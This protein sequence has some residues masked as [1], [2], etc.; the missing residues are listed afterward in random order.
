MP[1]E[2]P[3]HPDFDAAASPF[4]NAPVGP[5]PAAPRPVPQAPRPAAQ[6]PLAPQPA[7]V[8]PVTQR[9][10]SPQPAAVAYQRP[11]AAAPQPVAANAALRPI[12][13]KSTPDKHDF[14]VKRRREDDDE[15]R[16]LSE[17]L[18]EAPGWLV[19]SIIHMLL[20]IILGL[21]AATAAVVHNT[22]PMTVDS[23]PVE[24]PLLDYA[25]KLGQ[26]TIDENATIPVDHPDVGPEQI[27]TPMNL[28]PVDNPFASMSQLTDLSPTGNMAN[29]SDVQAPM[30]GLALKGREI[31]SKRVLL[32][33]Y[34]GNA[35]TEESVTKG[36]EWL[37]KQQL[38]DGTWSLT[39]PYSDGAQEENS[40]SATAMALLAF[41]GQGHTH[42]KGAFKE[43]VA[44]GWPALL[45]NLNADGDFFRAGPAHHRLYTQAQCTIALCELYGMSQ[46]SMYREQA[47]RAI[48]YAIKIQDKKGGWR[49]IP[50]EDSDTSVTGWFVMALQ[51]AKMARL[52]VA[53]LEDCLKNVSRYLDSAQSPTSNGTQYDYTPDT[54]STPAV[55][56]EGLLC[57]QYLG[58][59]Q[60]YPRLIDGCKALNRRRVDYDGDEVNV[61]Y[62]YYAT[63]ACHH[64]EGEIWKDWNAVMRQQIPSHQTKKGSEAGS[65]DP[66][67]DKYA[68]NGG[69]L[70]TTCLS[71]YML[72]VYYRHLPIYSGYKFLNSAGGAK[73]APA[74]AAPAADKPEKMDTPE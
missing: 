45:K 54:F 35:T 18:S 7:A 44:K 27:I 38:G 4:G 68:S 29:H 25:E 66:G 2:N 37:V 13:V 24:E 55:T 49:Y 67:R 28:P 39:G 51:S 36:L 71:I 56:A 60:N 47:T 14:G 40:I 23:A 52:D 22:A 5:R 70:Y 21:V 53:G 11:V 6:R 62:W 33:A 1:A 59:K 64:M 19:S 72:E 31:G 10:A 69:R 61:Y 9:P 26:Q 50:G 32:G 20:L 41:Q 8:Q 58:W 65:W 46:D 30:I 48:K 42:R 3:R 17:W 73:P 57:R 34:G 63:Q 16:T 12:V 74:A 15:Q 43:K